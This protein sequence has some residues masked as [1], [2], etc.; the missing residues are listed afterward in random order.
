M[1]V[2]KNNGVMDPRLMTTFGVNVKENDHPIGFF[3]T[4]F[5]YAI[6]VLLRNSCEVMVNSGRQVYQFGVME[7]E[8]RGKTFNRITMNGEPLAF[9]LDLGK[10][11]ELWQAYRELYSNCL[12]EG[13][14]V[15]RSNYAPE[16]KKDETVICV[17]GDAFEAVYAE[18][19]KYF[20]DGQRNVVESLSGVCEAYNRVYNDE[21]NGIIYYKGIRVGT[22]TRS[23]Y[24]YNIMDQIDL[25]EDR[26]IKYQ[27]Q[28]N[29]P[30]AKMFMHSK[31]KKLLRSILYLPS[32]ELPGY[33]HLIRY[34]GVL[35]YNEEPPQ[36][37]LDV[38]ETLL[39]QHGPMRINHTAY[40]LY[41]RHRKEDILPTE[42]VELTAVETKMYDRAVAFC[43]NALGMPVTKYPVIIADKLGDGVLGLAEMDDR[44]I[45]ISRAAFA[46][47]TKT[48]ACALV[49]EYTHLNTG[50]S[51][52]SFEQKWAYLDKIVSLGEE[53][54]GEPL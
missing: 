34:T 29:E 17:T 18:R 47:G 15:S 12:D 39:D 41:Q 46:K 3:G 37:F 40:E 50:C 49:E 30:I 9:T 20:L 25:T 6:A 13:G 27:F 22:L 24:D 45:Y 52:E 42:S 16:V 4:G 54:Q 10:K 19:G 26:T 5:K 51:D 11:W 48:L 8:I 31:K 1:I 23:R 33:E 32:G 28:V 2:F 35:N 38:I 7:E 36:R 43:M 21:P 44:I 14:T 53:L